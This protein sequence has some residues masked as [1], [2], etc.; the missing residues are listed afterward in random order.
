MPVAQ[1]PRAAAI[2]TALGLVEADRYIVIGVTVPNS[3]SHAKR[4]RWL[5]RTETV[6]E[7]SSAVVATTPMSRM[8]YAPAAPESISVGSP[9]RA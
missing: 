9:T 3:A 1:T 6:A 5:R 8:R 2:S 4:D 7:A